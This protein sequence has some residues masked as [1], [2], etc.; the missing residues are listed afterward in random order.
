[1]V[2]R[3][4]AVAY[5]AREGLSGQWLHD[6]GP[7][8]SAKDLPEFSLL[9]QRLANFHLD[10]EREDLPLWRWS[11]DGFYSA[12]LAYGA[13]FAGQVRAPISDEIWR[14]RGP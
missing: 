3:R 8:M 9:W 10:P 12:K 5:S 13:F 2:S 4:I 14:S 11:V 6:C 1:M 7:D